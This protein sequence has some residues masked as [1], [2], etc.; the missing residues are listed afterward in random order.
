MYEG[1]YVECSLLFPDLNQ[2]WI[3]QQMLETTIILKFANNISNIPHFIVSLKSSG[4]R[5]DERPGRRQ[6]LIS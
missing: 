4:S 2:A 1:Y 3:F 6:G 5:D